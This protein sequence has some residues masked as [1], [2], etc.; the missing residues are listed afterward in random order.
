MLNWLMVP[1]DKPDSKSD[2]SSPSTPE[3]LDLSDGGSFEPDQLDQP[4]KP[5]LKDLLIEIGSFNKETLIETDQLDT[6]EYHNDLLEEIRTGIDLNHVEPN[7]PTS[8]MTNL[9]YTL[10]FL[11]VNKR[12][13]TSGKDNKMPY[14]DIEYSSAYKNL[15][16]IEAGHRYR[17]T[18]NL[19][20]GLFLLSTVCILYGENNAF[21]SGM[22]VTSVALSG[23]FLFSN[24]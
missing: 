16:R 2:S 1:N 10:E 18:A 13:K 6:N 21:F 17:V 14:T 24:L 20:F 7:I 15:L 8:F 22:Y 12:I 23:S 3:A 11:I 5:D 9:R 4:V 19:G